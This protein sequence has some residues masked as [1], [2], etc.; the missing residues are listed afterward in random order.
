MY[1][2]KNWHKLAFVAL[3]FA[4]Y[5]VGSSLFLQQGETARTEESMAQMSDDSGHT[6][7][8]LQRQHAFENNGY[9]LG[10]LTVGVVSLLVFSD[11][12]RRLLKGPAISAL[13]AAPLF[14]L[15]GC[16]R[17]FEPV[18]LEVVAPNEEA[19]LLPYLGD[20]KKQ[21]SSNNEEYLKANLVY[22]KQVKIPQQWVPL[23]YEALGPNGKWQ[24]AAILV[25]VDK[26]PVTR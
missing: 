14:A 25:K 9:V 12:L 19:F 18:K 10:W 21:E 15:S 26:S 17:P 2:V 13:V 1:A 22:T 24:D 7:E 20:A 6:T 23:G 11:D 3:L 4:G 8:R 5:S 16:W